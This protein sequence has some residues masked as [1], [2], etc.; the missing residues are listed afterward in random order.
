MDF[1]SLFAFHM[2]PWNHWFYKK[3]GEIFFSQKNVPLRKIGIS[4]SPDN[5]FGS[6][7]NLKSSTF[8]G[9][10][11]FSTIIEPIWRI[12]GSQGP[13]FSKTVKFKPKK[14]NFW[15]K[16]VIMAQN[17]VGPWTKE[18]YIIK[19]VVL[20]LINDINPKK[21]DRFFGKM[22]Q[23]SAGMKKNWSR[24]VANCHDLKALSLFR[25]KLPEWH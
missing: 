6:C 13:P 3:N 2:A 21:K 19:W 18:K 11:F 10:H 25:T 14:S 5:I 24:L 7:K 20:G 9:K 17:S 4:W 12:L 23:K 16:M 1:W 15:R 8:H 22:T